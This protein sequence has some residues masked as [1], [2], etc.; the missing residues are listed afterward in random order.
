MSHAALL[1]FLKKQNSEIFMKSKGDIVF[2]RKSS[3]AYASCEE[4][5]ARRTCQSD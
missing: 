2:S 3:V 4:L 5:A 1:S